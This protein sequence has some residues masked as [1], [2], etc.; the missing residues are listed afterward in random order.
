[1]SFIYLLFTN[2]CYIADALLC[3]VAE[4]FVLEEFGR[5]FLCFFF[6]LILTILLK[7]DVWVFYTSTDTL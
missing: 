5:T 4:E 1:M 2:V 7:P 6:T 3:N